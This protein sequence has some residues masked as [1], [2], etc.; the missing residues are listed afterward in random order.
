MMIIMHENATQEEISG[1]VAR[2]E[3]VGLGAHLVH[4]EERTIIGAIGDGRPVNRDQFLVL[5]GVDQVVP[6]SRPYKIASREF[7]PHN[8][9]FPLDGVAVGGTGVVII[10][11]PCSVES[12]HPDP[13]DRPRR[14]RGRRSRPARR[15]LQAPHLPLLLPGPGRGRPR[16]PRRSPLAHRPPRRHRGH[17]PR[18]RPPRRL[19]RRRPPDRRPQH[20]ELRPPPRR[21]REPEARPGQARHVRHRRGAAHGRRVR[22]LPRQPPRHALRA[23]H[24]HLRNLHPQHHRHQRHPR[25]QVPHPPPRPPRPLPRHRQLGV[26]H[27]RG[28]RR[29]R[30]RRRWLDRRGPHPPR[31]GPLGRRPV[32]QARTLRRDGPPGQGHRPGHRHG[33]SPS[34]ATRSTPPPEPRRDEL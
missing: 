29:H 17:G 27:R 21:R 9:V 15:R 32:P 30:R 28:P 8:T 4:G 14:Q 7:S 18:T 3:S 33:M 13:R 10:A 20:A 1:V 26:R 25:A 31:P 6:I 11:G 16:V 24:P 22:P 34:R 5:P 2:I 12:P 19:L 23:R